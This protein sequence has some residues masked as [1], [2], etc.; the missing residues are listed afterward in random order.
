VSGNDE[1][2]VPERPYDGALIGIERPAGFGGITV[3]HRGAQQAYEQRSG[4][5]NQRQQQAL[6]QRKSRLWGGL[7]CGNGGRW[8]GHIRYCNG[9][10]RPFFSALGLQYS[11][12]LAAVL[13][14][15]YRAGL[16]LSAHDLVFAPE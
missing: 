10:Q 16:H 12:P 5:R 3:A 1:A 13:R 8:R 7:T 15:L 4:P 9:W 14:L 6:A 11:R 2:T